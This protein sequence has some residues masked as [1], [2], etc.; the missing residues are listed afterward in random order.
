MAITVTS[1]GMNVS[2]PALSKPSR[3]R[4]KRGWLAGFGSSPSISLLMICYRML[5]CCRGETLRASSR[6]AG[7]HPEGEA[8]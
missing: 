8:A 6:L 1:V 7:A 4:V 2:G 5:F 3:G